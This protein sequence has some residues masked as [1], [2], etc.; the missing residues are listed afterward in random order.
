LPFQVDY[1]VGF[2]PFGQFYREDDTAYGLALQ[3]DF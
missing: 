2:S 1:Y 3:F